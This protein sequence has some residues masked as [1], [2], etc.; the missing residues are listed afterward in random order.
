ML[1]NPN[2]SPSSFCSLVLSR[3][4]RSLASNYEFPVLSSVCQV[5]SG[6]SWGCFL[7]SLGISITLFSRSNGFLVTLKTCFVLC[8]LSSS[9]ECTHPSVL[10]IPWLAALMILLL[11]CFRLYFGFAVSFSRTRVILASLSTLWS[12]S[13]TLCPPLPPCSIFIKYSL[14][15]AYTV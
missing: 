14:I 12:C 6:F 10:S 1:A 15:R 2:T 9:W 5:L 11:T 13:T 7:T 4:F 8:V 3:S